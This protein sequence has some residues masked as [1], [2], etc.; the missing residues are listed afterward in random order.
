M[1]DILARFPTLANW[2]SD[3]SKDARVRH[4][5]GGRKVLNWLAEHPGETW[6]ERWLVSGADRDIAW[7]EMMVARDSRRP[8]TARDELT[9]GL[10][11]LL[12]GQLIR[13]SY[14]FIHACRL[15]SLPRWIRQSRR[16]ELF[17]QL[18]QRGNELATR[19]EEVANALT[20]LSWIVLHTGREVDQLTAQDVLNYRAWRRGQAQGRSSGGIGGLALSWVL[21]REVA[22]LGDHLTLKDA[23]RAGQR[24]T[25]ELVDGYGIRTRAVRDVL[26]RYLDERRP[27]LDYASFRMLT[28][29]LAGRFWADIERHRPQVDSL[30][31]SN[32]VAAAWKH[33][34]KT[35][36]GRDGRSRPRQDYFA[37][38]NHVRSFYRDLQE[39]A[40]DDPAWVAFSVPSPI[41]RSD[42]AGLGKQIKQTT[43]RM[44]QRVQER[45]PRL[46][47][48]VDS[49]E[50]HRLAQTAFRDAATS[51]PL[52]GL[53]DHL[54][55]TYRRVLPRSYIGGH[56]R[57]LVPRVR[58]QRTGDDTVIDLDRVEH[59]AFWAWA[60]IETL[61]H[62]GVRV[63]ELL[64]ISHLA[65]IAYTLP[66]TGE[67]VPML[68]IVPSKSNEER[69]LLVSPELASVLATI[70]TRLRRDNDG[71]VPLTSRYDKKE[72]A[73]G[74][75]LPHLFQHRIGSQW[76]TFS[77]ATIKELLQ[78]ALDRAGLADPTGQPLQYTPHDFRR[79]FATDAVT[80]G[81]PVHIA[82]RVLGHA[83]LQTTQG[84]LA[85][86]NDDIV[87]SYRSY[88][89]KRRAT[90]PQAEYREPT[91]Q[92][93]ADFQQHFQ[94]RKLELGD[95][96]RPYG[97]P[98]QHEHACVRCPMLH[99]DP[100][101]R[102]RLVEIVANL[103]D[104][105][106]EA[107]LNGW[108]GEVEGL[109]TSLTAATA[110][111]ADLDRTRNRHLNSEP[112]TIGMPALGRSPSLE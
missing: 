80:G 87:R 47:D 83:N 105:I 106:A 48:L 93:W 27:A 34:L 62:T 26:V 3:A 55:C 99:V 111:L 85:V 70:I 88:L 79:I 52:D 61:R 63:E 57:S 72:R 56:D 20:V 10:S 24:P 44:H 50:Q 77:E 71:A 11:S 22:D 82:S 78:A 67:T 86:F 112:V 74:P 17:A 90:R 81:L 49:A 35:V 92:E 66:D 28:G 69:L 84:Y 76:H 101:Q 96:G 91:Q 41:R 98:C 42:L 60:V 109:T 94:L 46:P 13:P 15:T 75:R 64:E 23:L 107:R 102:G 40:H 9:R 97:T 39:W 68:Q 1:N 2:P 89:D 30:K 104:R 54:G 5:H 29:S 110:K 16:P 38:L 53:F 33:R 95:C 43:A 14:A 108:L 103:R 65:L 32:E 51:V 19:S 100:R 37:L 73:V 12:L 59:D 36:T 25:A 31:L 45:L 7:V 21:L 6:Q 8:H 18:Q 4:I 58:V